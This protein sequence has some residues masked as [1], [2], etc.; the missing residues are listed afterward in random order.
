MLHATSCSRVL[1]V[2]V[3]LSVY[4][5]YRILCP[6]H[7][8]SSCR[9]RVQPAFWSSMLQEAGSPEVSCTLLNSRRDAVKFEALLIDIFVLLCSYDLIDCS[10]LVHFEFADR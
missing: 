5:I 6:C 9:W 10:K 7:V 3:A 2:F 8:M 4:S 1:L